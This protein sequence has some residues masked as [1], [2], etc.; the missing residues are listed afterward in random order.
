ML[1]KVS[2][3][4]K[5][6]GGFL[7]I[8]ILLILLAF[9]G[10]VGLNQVVVKVKAA[11]Q[12][13]ALVSH[14]LTA[15]QNEKSFILNQSDDAVKTVE[16][17]IVDLKSLGKEIQANADSE[18]TRNQ[19][20][21]ILKLSGQYEKAFSDYVSLARNKDTLMAEMNQKA[22]TALEITSNIRDDQKQKYD[23]LRDESETRIGTLRTRVAYAAKINEAYLVA[24]GYRRALT[25]INIE[26]KP[27]VLVEWK[28]RHK[29]LTNTCNEVASLLED[30]TSK[31]GLDN[32]LTTQKDIMEKAQA[33]F[34]DKTDENN[35]AVIKAAKAFQRRV[36][37]F[38]QEMQEQLEFYV[39]D[40]QI[41]SGQM[42]DLSSGADQIAKVL[43]N[44][45]ILEK[46]YIRTEDE[47]IFKTITES[48][49]SIDGIIAEIKENIDDEDKTKPL[50][51]IQEAVKNYLTSFTSY[52]DMMKNQQ[53]VSTEMESSAGNI[54]TICSA[55]K[56]SQQAGMQK[57]ISNSQFLILAGSILALVAGC[58]IAFILT[59]MILTPIKKVLF[60][61]KDIAQGDGDLTQRI[62]IR[63]RD[64][65]GQ[66][67]ESFNAFVAKLN[68]I[69]VD[70]GVNS[71]TVTAASGELLVVS[72]QM[73]EEADDL[74]SRSNS[75]AAAAEEM[76]ANMNS[77]AAASEEA[78][79]NVGMVSDSAGQMKV[80]LNEVAVNCDKAREIS[81][82]AAQQVRHASERVGL[83]GDA[84]REISQVTEVITEIAEQTNLLALN[85][86]IEAARAGEA[87]RGF[88]VV[89]SEIKGLANQTANATLDIR[90][91]ISGIQHSTDDTVGDVEKITGVISDVTEIVNT[92]AAAI[93]EQSASASEVATNIDQASAGIAEVN[94][95]VAQSSQVSSEI[96]QD[97]SQVNTVAEEISQKGV[98]MNRSAQDLSKLSSKLRDMIS[99]FK[100]SIEE[101]DIDD[102]N[103]LNEEDIPDLMAWGPKLETG[104][105]EIDSQHQT[106][107]RLVNQLH[108]AMKL[109]HGALES[110]KVLSELADYTVQHFAHEEELFDK[111]GYPETGS[112]KEIHENLVAKVLEFQ[113]E[114][115]SG[116]ASLSME[117]MD[118]LTSW[119][120]SHIMEVDMAYVPYL[121]EKLGSDNASK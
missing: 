110:G 25:E 8:L 11:N 47:R 63:T 120:R 29:D 28:M 50:E 102:P 115:K 54:Q 77:V 6:T 108:R 91:K 66:L 83:L 61:L 106:L 48:I 12:Y 10:R 33:F 13:E 72:E 90:E 87:G 17:E 32:I 43:L 16:R 100:V 53:T 65:I 49:S 73:S 94:E 37:N 76:S 39:E 96:A 7:I 42:M 52:A 23:S 118:F 27:S 44:T 55:G 68:S 26:E 20:A 119:L 46:E 41:F 113:K 82:N 85:A 59:R 104:I 31:K 117:L 1:N 3:A 116:S 95:N 64:E 4:K 101:A 35:L 84:A 45:R 98:Q 38:Q 121:K 21:D 74:N 34:A 57:Q 86:T 2:L 92:I 88:A 79:T 36:I 70:I 97:I 18:D 71:E 103:D 80:T 22:S 78:S 67:A 89:A 60:A 109:K 75:V 111:Y 107:V 40:V 15:R 56:E 99:I 30:D 112:H 5:I 62:E 24:T 51:G 114:F 9:V 93:D 105:D 14:I 69:I 19:I 58:V 81:E